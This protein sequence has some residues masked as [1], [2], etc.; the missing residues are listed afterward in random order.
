MF[1]EK[2]K[3]QGLHMTI[4][5]DMDIYRV[6]KTDPVTIKIPVLSKINTAVHLHPWLALWGL[7]RRACWF[8]HCYI[9]IESGP[10][11]FAEVVV[12]NAMPKLIDI[13][14]TSSIPQ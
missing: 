12:K 2:K 8:S 14:R 11:F 7:W 9:L 6:G 13:R 4:F 1:L 5:R 10:F 3:I